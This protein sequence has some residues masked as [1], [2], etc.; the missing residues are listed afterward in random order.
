MATPNQTIRTALWFA[1]TVASFIALSF[2]MKKGYNYFGTLLL[3]G[4]LGWSISKTYAG[5]V[6]LYKS[7]VKGQATV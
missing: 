5:I 4:A 7:K 1:A 2:W 6:Q 3:A